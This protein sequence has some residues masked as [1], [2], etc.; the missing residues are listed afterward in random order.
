MLYDAHGTGSLWNQIA[1]MTC[2]DG[3]YAILKPRHRGGE[4]ESDRDAVVF[5]VEN[6]NCDGHLKAE[7][8]KAVVARVF[9][10]YR[11]LLKRKE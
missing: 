4:K 8:D 9:E 3:L 7:C 10:E 1:V 6:F 11:R 5:R 2:R